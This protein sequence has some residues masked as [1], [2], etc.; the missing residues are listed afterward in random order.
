MMHFPTKHLFSE[1]VSPY[2][3]SLIMKRRANIPLTEREYK[4]LQIFNESVSIISPT[5]HHHKMGIPAPPKTIEPKSFDELSDEDE[6]D[7]QELIDDF[8]FELELND[9]LR[10]MGYNGE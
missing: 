4:K 1:A 8:T 3:K 10:E 6:L 5:A 2:I 7:I 9:I